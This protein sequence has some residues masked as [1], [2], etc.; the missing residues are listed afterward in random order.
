MDGKLRGAAAQFEAIL[1]AQL[2][3]ALN[4]SS[5]SDDDE[6]KLFGSDGGTGMAKQMFAEQ[7]AN[8]IAQAGGVGLADLIMQRF[9]GNFVKN[10]N[11]L[12]PN[13]LMPK[14]FDLKTGENRVLPLPTT[15]SFQIQDVENKQENNLPEPLQKVEP[16][17]IKVSPSRLAVQEIRGAGFLPEVNNDSPFMPLIEETNETFYQPETKNSKSGAEIISTVEVTDEIRESNAFIEKTA[18]RANLAGESSTKEK[19]KKIR[20]QYR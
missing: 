16:K 13:N 19:S 11:N 15:K 17:Q 20:A 12:T 7:L 6:N 10:P 9:E 8:S 14:K 4:A 18:N 5:E 2:T 1:L 3:S